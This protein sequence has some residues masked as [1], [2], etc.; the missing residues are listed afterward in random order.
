MF[1][2]KTLVLSFDILRIN[3]YVTSIFAH[4]CRSQVCYWHE[5]V[6]LGHMKLLNTNRS[7]VY[8]ESNCRIRFELE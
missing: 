4:F 6:E 3:F 1:L 2:T 8:Q 7:F 5:E